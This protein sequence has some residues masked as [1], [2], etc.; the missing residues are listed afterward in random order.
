MSKRQQ[1]MLCVRLN[2]LGVRKTQVHLIL[3]IIDKWEEC[4]GTEWTVNRLKSLKTLWLNRE[5]G[6]TYEL[7]WVSLNKQTGVPNGP[8]SSLFAKGMSL[9]N[10]G[11]AINALMLYSAFIAE[12]HTEAQW[13]KFQKAVESPEPRKEMQSNL[14]LRDIF[15]EPISKPRKITNF[16]W[17]ESKRAP[18][19]S[20]THSEASVDAWFL[21]ALEQP[22]IRKMI[23]RYPKH[24]TPV[25]EG[26]PKKLLSQRPRFMSKKNLTEEE[27][28]G[29]VGRIGF[30]QEPG[31]KLRVVAN[32]NRI[33]QLALEPLK[34]QCFSLLIQIEEDCTFDQYE[35][36]EFAE[37]A[38]KRGQTV[39]SI[40]L[41]NATDMFPL[42][43]QMEICEKYGLD[44][45][46]LNHFHDIAVSPWDVNDPLL[47]KQRHISWKKGQPLGLGPSFPM[48]ALAHHVVVWTAANNIGID[49]TNAYRILGDDIIILNDDL[50]DE[51]L[52]IMDNLGCPVSKDKTLSSNKLC[53]FAGKIIYPDGVI[54]TVKWRDMS[55]RNFT[56]YVSFFGPRAIGA[57]KTRQ[58]NVIARISEL[59][60]FVGGMGWNPHGKTLDQRLDENLSL[61]QY[62]SETLKTVSN[63]TI[64]LDARIALG[65]V[66]NLQ[67]VSQ[68][69]GQQAM[70]KERQSRTET[71]IKSGWAQ[72][73]LDIQSNLVIL[74]DVVLEGIQ[75]AEHLNSSV[76]QTSDPRGRSTLEVW[77]G[78]LVKADRQTEL[79]K[80]PAEPDTSQ[81]CDVD[82]NDVV[83]DVINETDLDAL[84]ET[85]FLKEELIKPNSTRGRFQK[86]LDFESWVQI[87]EQEQLQ[88]QAKPETDK[89]AIDEEAKATKPKA[90]KVKKRTGIKPGF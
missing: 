60:D 26:L 4:S 84:Y 38:L 5:A 8:F 82:K 42:D 80:E 76:R 31:Y 55:D 52:K 14:H 6:Q 36:V 54:P 12:D 88:Q 50:K 72:S 15:P 34:D 85:F 13:K 1:N 83:S 44:K 81:V 37:S 29:A 73:L 69:P 40:D 63:T 74:D 27:Q 47:K 25:L 17:S 56:D 24:Y 57:L 41:S 19:L 22:R 33:T 16:P 75:H 45:E 20:K 59:P 35:G 39:H 68:A 87:R 46:Y 7:P 58:R 71:G 53:E 3:N 28:V 61:I 62:D 77:E 67:G 65:L 86:I 32:P 49:S 66:P 10:R 23:N 48:F 51:Y 78:K 90:R 89:T 70:V 2:S 79:V 11:K 30:I 18:G 43:L 9:K 64:S 21:D